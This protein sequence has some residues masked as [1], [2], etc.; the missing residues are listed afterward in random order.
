M[1]PTASSQRRLPRCVSARADAL[2]VA[3]T[4][5]LRTCTIRHM[6]DSWR[7]FSFLALVVGARLLL[8]TATRA[9]TAQGT[10]PTGVCS[11]TRGAR[12]KPGVVRPGAPF[13]LTAAQIQW[14]GSRW[15]PRDAQ[16]HRIQILSRVDHDRTD[17]LPITQALVAK[18]PTY[19][20]PAVQLPDA[21]S[22]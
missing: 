11:F 14:D 13:T 9:L 5:W 6:R 2:A 20:G 3:L 7:S 22:L 8:F 15:Q 19:K 16:G 10:G 21:V 1:P 12:L 4:T 17:D 18:P